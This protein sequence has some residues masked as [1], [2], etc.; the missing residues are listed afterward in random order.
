M[1]SISILSGLA[2]LISPEVHSHADPYYIFWDIIVKHW[3]VW[4][5]ISCGEGQTWHIAE[6][7]TVYVQQEAGETILK[8]RDRLRYFFI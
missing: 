1:L 2:R 7:S 5:L 8:Y 4:L 6:I 3:T